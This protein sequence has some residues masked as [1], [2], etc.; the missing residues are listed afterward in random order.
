MVCPL[1]FFVPYC[2]FIFD[3][4]I[5]YLDPCGVWAEPLSVGGLLAR[6]RLGG[7]GLNVVCPLL[8]FRVKRGLSPI[9]FRLKT[10]W[11]SNLTQRPDTKKPQRLVSD[12]VSVC[13][14]RP[15][16]GFY[17]LADCLRESALRVMGRIKRGLSPIV[18]WIKR[19][20]SPIVS[21]SM[22]IILT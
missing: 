7:Y 2:L 15:L 21:P 17:L 10:A 19:G 11:V 8:L 22:G 13:L 3:P 14:P 16:W 12:E 4:F 5:F 20:L 1:L 9:V 6:I 18:F